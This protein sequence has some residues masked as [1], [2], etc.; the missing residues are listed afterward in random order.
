MSEP[1]LCSIISGVFTIAAVLITRS[2]SAKTK[3]SKGTQN[4]GQSP[5]VGANKEDA[6]GKPA[7]AGIEERIEGSTQ[8]TDSKPSDSEQLFVLWKETIVHS[9]TIVGAML[10]N[11]VVLGV[12]WISIAN[13]EHRD[14]VDTLIPAVPFILLTIWATSTFE[15]MYNTLK[16]Q[17]EKMLG[18]RAT[19][20][21]T[22]KTE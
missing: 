1:I 16:Q 2:R 19:N 7:E 3:A 15:G 8:V 13:K 9:G 12:M 11:S 20:G 10:V 18:K 5:S 21:N 14:W 22:E 4:V 17:R 6:I